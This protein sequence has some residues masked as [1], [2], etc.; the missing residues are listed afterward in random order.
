MFAAIANYIDGFFSRIESEARK[1]LKKRLGEIV[2]GRFVGPDAERVTIRGL[3]EDYLNDYR[4]N[5]RKSFEK[6]EEM[7]TRLDNEGNKKDSPLMACF[8][9]CKAHGLRADIWER[10]RVPAIGERR[11]QRHDQP[12]TGGA[13]AH[14]QPRFEVRANL[15][16]ALYTDA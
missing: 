12:R 5:G 15:P 1:L 14:V 16:Q 11:G 8:G 7:V 4:V 13:Q 10:L 3:A 6:A 2:L 9:D